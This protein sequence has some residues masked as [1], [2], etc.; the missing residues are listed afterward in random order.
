M[1]YFSFI[2]LIGATQALRVADPK[3]PEYRSEFYGDTWRYTDHHRLANE[4][5]WA[6]DAPQAYVVMQ[7]K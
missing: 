1:K 7:L 6:A 3:L 5:E 2:A 4:E